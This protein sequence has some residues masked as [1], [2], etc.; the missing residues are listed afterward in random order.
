VTAFNEP[1][2]EYLRA[3]TEAGQRASLTISGSDDHFRVVPVRVSYDE[4]EDAVE[5]AAPE[6]LHVGI[7][8][9]PSDT[10]TVELVVDD[11]ASIEPWQPRG[12]AV[13]GTAE[14]LSRPPRVRI[15]P[16]SVRSWGLE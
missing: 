9:P 3:S 10:A 16:E 7:N 5:I 2:L 12:V 1:E 6:A 14:A 15:R 8:L 13:T 11:L 4:L